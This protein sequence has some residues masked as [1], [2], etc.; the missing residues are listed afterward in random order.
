MVSRFK[1][2]TEEERDIMRRSLRRFADDLLYESMNGLADSNEM[3]MKV[4]A[5]LFEVVK[6]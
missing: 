4:S 1:D 2:F 5:L 6:M 3:Y